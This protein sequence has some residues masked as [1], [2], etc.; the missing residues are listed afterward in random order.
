MGGGG[1]RGTAHIGVLR[2]LQKEGIPI[3]YLAG[4]SIGSIVG[5]LYCAGVSLDDIEHMITDKSLQ[6]AYA[7]GW[8]SWAILL[9]PTRKLIDKMTF[10][11]RPYAGLFAGKKFRAF[12]SKKLPADKQNIEDL[13]I[14]F[15]AVCTNLLDGKAYKLAKGNFATAVLASSAIPPAVRPVEINGNLFIDGAIRSNVPVISAKQFGAD[16]V[17]AVPVD[18]ALRQE[19]LKK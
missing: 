7:P 14:P 16:L 4:C 8:L 9:Y 18:E 5:G 15:V 11:D 10:Q 19:T 12:L 1:V 6:K 3:D 13:N 2:V 17:I